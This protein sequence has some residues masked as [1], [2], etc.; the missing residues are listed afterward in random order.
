[1]KLH[2]KDT[3]RLISY[4][5]LAFNL[6]ENYPIALLFPLSKWLDGYLKFPDFDY[7]LRSLISPRIP[8]NNS[9]VSHPEFHPVVVGQSGSCSN[10][11]PDLFIIKI[12]VDP[13]QPRPEYV[14]KRRGAFRRDNCNT[15][16]I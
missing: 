13:K 11:S 3:S 14:W 16:P 4:P 7:A 6:T 5:K 12:S 9:P 15:A 2:M 10:A 1:M 8:L